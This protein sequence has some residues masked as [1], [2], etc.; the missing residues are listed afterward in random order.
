MG[1]ENSVIN[2][3]MC[4][5]QSIASLDRFELCEAP[6]R[7]LAKQMESEDMQITQIH[8]REFPIIINPVPYYKHSRKPKKHFTIKFPW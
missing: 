7:K 2:Q 8:K 5:N 4:E 1:K 6:Q 3:F